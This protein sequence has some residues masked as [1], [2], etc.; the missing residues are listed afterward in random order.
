MKCKV[1]LCIIF[2]EQ[3]TEAVH[4]VVRLRVE[5]S[6]TVLLAGVINFTTTASIPDVYITSS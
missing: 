6:E 3:S 4:R 2:C 1:V 5:V